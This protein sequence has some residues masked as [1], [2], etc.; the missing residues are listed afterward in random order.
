MES[1]SEVIWHKYVSPNYDHLMLLEKKNEYEKTFSVNWDD[2]ESGRGILSDNLDFDYSQ[3]LI[4][5]W[6]PAVSVETTW[7]V[8]I[9]Y[10][11]DFFYPDD[12]NIVILAKGKKIK[13]HYCEENLFTY[14]TKEI[15]SF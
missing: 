14:K 6:S 1:D 9:N 11:T 8:V 12:D 10:W 7:G 15:V 2:D 13:I 3:V 5:M 4:F